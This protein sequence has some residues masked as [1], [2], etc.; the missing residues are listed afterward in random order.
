M[1]RLI[2]NKAT[3]KK[4]IEISGSASTKMNATKACRFLSDLGIGSI[5]GRDY[6]ISSE[7]RN[8]LRA[9][10]KAEH[11]IDWSKGVAILEGSRTQVSKHAVEGKLGRK[12]IKANW[13]KIK[14]L[15]RGHTISLDGKLLADSP[16]MHT[17]F[18]FARLSDMP[19]S[20]DSLLLVENL[21]TFNDIHLAG[22]E[23][24]LGSDVAVIFRGD[25]QSTGAIRF[26]KDI[27]ATDPR[28][29]SVAFC[30]FDPAGMEILLSTGC[31][32][33]IMPILTDLNKINGS[34]DDYSAQHQQLTRL[35]DDDLVPEKVR[36]YLDYLNDKKAGFTQE[37]MFAK[38]IHF[39]VVN[40]TDH[41]RL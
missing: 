22:L 37:R 19:L 6:V 38:S 15:T 2:I 5:I 31:T 29:I 24:L 30:D 32:K 13:V 10:L 1:G 11:G 34:K 39:E 16:W 23:L 7:Q 17:E 27:T 20:C 33:A 26:F 14:P 41:S 21:E 35:L 25:P 12:A 36:H 18:D 4:A 40:L 3:V 8:H 28:I 9:W